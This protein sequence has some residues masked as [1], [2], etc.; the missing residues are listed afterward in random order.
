MRLFYAIFP[1]KAIQQALGQAQQKVQGFKGWKPVP[2]HQLHITLLFLGEQPK[3]RLPQLHRVGQ[4]VAASVPAFQVTL[5]GTGYFPPVG[6][7]RVWFVK[8]R[9]EGLEALAQGLRQ[10]LPDI[11]S[12]DV[13]HAHLTLARKKRPAPRIGPLVFDLCFEARV[14]CLVESRLEP[15]GSVYRVLAQFPL[16]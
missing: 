10:A 16:S 2:P 5:G 4:A 9:G 12:Q 11:P 7:P 15:S 6:S 14:L 8:A 1:P 13:F 3:E